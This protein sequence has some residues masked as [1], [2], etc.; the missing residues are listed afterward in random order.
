MEAAFDSLKDLPGAWGEMFAEAID[1]GQDWIETFILIASETNAF[2][3]LFSLLGVIAMSMPPNF[4]AEMIAVGVGFLLP[5][6]IIELIIMLIVGL[7]GGAAF[8][9]LAARAGVFL[10]K[11]R[12]LGKTVKAADVLAEIVVAFKAIASGLARIGRALRKL[13]DDVG[14][15]AAGGVARIRRQLNQYTV[16]I[17]PNTLGMNGG[18]TKITRKTGKPRGPRAKIN[19]KMRPDIQRS[20]HR[21]NDSADILARAGH[22]VEQNPKVPGDKDPDYKIDGE[23]YD[24]YAPGEETPVRN[25]WD[26]VKRKIDKRQT[27]NV[28]LNLQDYDGDL[29][30][31]KKQFNDW[32][33]D[34]LNDMIVIFK[35]GSIGSL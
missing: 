26:R 30:A 11:L 20:M 12:K 5:E 29:G 23:I 14:E 1:K 4:W 8:P 6:L 24:N 18:N 35:D 16:E 17:D 27:E 3:Y 19:D 25:I 2:E 7:T 10:A 13:L 22:D 28:V 32:P 33:I 21:E 9:A 31:L 15:A 34:G